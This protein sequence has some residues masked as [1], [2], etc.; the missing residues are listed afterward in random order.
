MPAVEKITWPGLPESFTGFENEPSGSQNS[1]AGRVL[2]VGRK[3]Y[4]PWI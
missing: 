2:V 4:I 1:E 3:Y